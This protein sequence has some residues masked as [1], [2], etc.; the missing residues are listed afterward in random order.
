MANRPT[1]SLLA[2]PINLDEARVTLVTWSDPLITGNP[3]ATVTNSADTLQWW[4]PVLGPSATLTAYFAAD[5]LA[6]NGD[7]PVELGVVDLA[8]RVGHGRTLHRWLTTIERLAGFAVVGVIGQ[9]D[10][11]LAIAVRSHLGPLTARQRKLLPDD[12]RDLYA[13]R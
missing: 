7:D 3:Q 2:V 10:D 6:R 8:R 11:H 1:P 12:L 4:T 13:R 9:T 5:L